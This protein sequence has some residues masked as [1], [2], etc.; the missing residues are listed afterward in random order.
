[1]DKD[2]EKLAKC[3]SLVFPALSSEQVQAATTENV[4][5]WDSVA[6]LNLVVLISVEFGVPMDFEEFEGVTSFAGFLDRLR[7]EKHD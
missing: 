7:S 5:R 3:F 6:Q 4:S 2:T 1:M